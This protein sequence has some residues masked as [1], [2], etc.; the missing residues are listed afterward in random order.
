MKYTLPVLVLRNDTLL[1]NTNDSFYISRERS[2]QA[3]K[4]AVDRKI[5]V[6]RQLDKTKEYIG[7]EI[8]LYSNGVLAEITSN[9][10]DRIV[11]GRREVVYFSGISRVKMV[12]LVAVEPYIM[13]EVED[14]LDDFDENSVQTK[15]L[16]VK[17][18]E[19]LKD[20]SEIMK[21]N[22]RVEITDKYLMQKSN[23][24]INSEIFMDSEVKDLID[25]AKTKSIDN[26]TY[27]ITKT[28]VP[29]EKQNIL[30]IK[31]VYTRMINIL[32]FIQEIIDGEKIK[33]EIEDS[34]KNRSKKNQKEAII[35]EQ[36]R[37]LTEELGESK[38]ETNSLKERID[39]K[40]LPEEV[41]NKLIKEVERMEAIS[42][43]SPDYALLNNHVD[44]VLS[45][46]WG[47]YSEDI[48]DLKKAREILDEDH[49]GLERVKKLILE[50]L[51][52]KKMSKNINSPILCLVGA[53]GVG[54]TSIA[55]SIARAMDKDFINMSLGGLHDESEIRGHRKTYVGA[56]PGRIIYNMTKAKTNNPV[57]L[58][59]EID[60]VA[61]DAR[62]DP[63]SA[64][65][66]VLD[67][68]QNAFFRDN[69]VEVPYDLSKVFFITTANDRSAIQKP[70]LDRM[71]VIEMSSYTIEEKFEIA[72]RYLEPK[73]R[74]NAGFG[75]IKVSVADEAI[76]EIIENYTREAGV[77]EL[78]RNFIAIYRKLALEQVEDGKVTKKIDKKTVNRLL[79]VSLGGDPDV[80]QGEIGAVNGLAWT[81]VGGVMMPIE[82]RLLPEGKGDIILTGKLGDVMKESAR[83]AV[84]LIKSNLH[85]YNLDADLFSKYD[86]HIHAPDGATPKD[87]PS[88]GVTITTAIMSAI[89]KRPVV[90]NLAMTGEISLRGKVMAIGGLKEKTIAAERSGIKKVIIPSE[91]KK[92]LEDL[93]KSVAD[94]LE[95]VFADTISDVLSNA[96][97][98]GI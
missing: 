32:S 25:D 16:R 22:N 2:M 56:M 26:L 36:I 86:I 77:R 62:S 23:K 88:A 91:N 12:R 34:V 51:A 9:N 65:L 44:T 41:Q 13:A 31:S 47:I 64:L 73:A 30:Q 84:S 93:P 79:G 15:T 8:E 29:E 96:F 97:E 53:P 89:L 50:F 72:K 74:K 27:R 87:G 49:F 45:L 83:I 68:A 81:S 61:R 98:G 76:Y 92:N 78:E 35:R 60:K 95:F 17:V 39:A 20:F 52:V 4:A 90:K 54:K 67:P 3:L 24:E 33:K 10:L 55:K 7:S 63:S 48:I 38:A 70:L 66:E 37:L 43:A 14:D 75:D 58:L 46:P 21:K 42:P 40:N 59:D 6:F 11:L 71:E 19:I 18:I 5:L 94:K 85:N 69:Y 80:V 28:I 1:P 57:F 82:V